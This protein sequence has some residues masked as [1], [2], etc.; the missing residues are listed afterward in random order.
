MFS[1][2]RFIPQTVRHAVILCHGYGASGDDMA[3]LIPS[4]CS[5]LPDT[6]FFCPNGV[7]ELGFNS[8]EWFSLDDYNAD[9]MQNRAYLSILMN[10]LS[11]PADI[12]RHMMSDIREKYGISSD[13]IALGGFSQG[14]LLAMYTALTDPEKT[15]GVIGMS[16]APILF[17]ET[18]P[19]SEIR[20][21]PPV[22]LTHGSADMVVPPAGL[23]L[24]IEQLNAIGIT[25]DVFVS[26]GMGHSIDEAC[27]DHIGR[28]LKQCFGKN[29]TI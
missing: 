3:G 15:A 19:V 12:I 27:I 9:C 22:I 8:Y 7:K 4:F 25:P 21:K 16:A 26:N 13:N 5:I 20:Q 28:F 1:D 11:A 23:A 10:R 2:P 17:G 14:G 6:A 29:D 24:N 18:L